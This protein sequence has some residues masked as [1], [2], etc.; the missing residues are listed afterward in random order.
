MKYIL[1]IFITAISNYTF[2]QIEKP[3]D[4]VLTNPNYDKVL[5]EKLGANEYGMKS[6]FLVILKSGTNQTTD[7]EE[8]NRSFRSHME[9]INYLV[10]KGKLIV[11]GPLS[12]NPNNLRGIFILQNLKTEEEV[13]EILQNDLAIKNNLLSFEI[14]TWYGSAALS[15]YLPYSDKI[16]KVKP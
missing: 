12:K 4:S 1:L 14:L 7:K 16:W 9:N 11:A 10:D 6:Y 13:K 5:A 15:E 2:G 8:I 3:G